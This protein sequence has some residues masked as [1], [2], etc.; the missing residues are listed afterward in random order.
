MIDSKAKLTRKN[1]TVKQSIEPENKKS[2]KKQLIIDSKAEI[3]QKSKFAVKQPYEPEKKSPKQLM[4]DSQQKMSK[5]STTEK[6]GYKAHRYKAHRYK[7]RFFI[8]G[9]QRDK[10]NEIFFKI[11]QNR[12]FRF[13]KGSF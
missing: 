7:A 1:K 2:S 5:F 10:K 3:T 4:I 11:A 9:T 8:K 12:V 6:V 13:L